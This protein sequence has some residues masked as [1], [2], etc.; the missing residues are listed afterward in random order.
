MPE[1]IR[2]H[3]RRLTLSIPKEVGPRLD[4]INLALDDEYG[5]R[6]L[7][8]QPRT[9]LDVGANFGLFSLLAA[10][11]FP[12]AAIHAYEPEPTDFSRRSD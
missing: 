3:G 7:P 1:T 4:F 11:Y 8:F 10:H 12:K 2:L 6:Q 9:I 5:L